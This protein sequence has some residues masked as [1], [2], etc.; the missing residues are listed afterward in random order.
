LQEILSLDLHETDVNSIPGSKTRLFIDQSNNWLI[1]TNQSNIWI[2]VLYPRLNLI[3]EIFDLNNTCIKYLGL[4]LYLRP[5]KD[6]RT[7]RV[8]VAILFH[9]PEYSSVS[10]V[11]GSVYFVVFRNRLYRLGLNMRLF[12]SETVKSGEIMVDYNY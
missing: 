4:N 10:K 5:R 12:V 2:E 6:E 11:K 3:S 7:Y 9:E 1:F 8:K